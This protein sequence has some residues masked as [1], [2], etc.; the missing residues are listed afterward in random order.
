MTVGTA[1]TGTPQAPSG[2]GFGWVPGALV[3]IAI[4]AVA[5]A[6]LYFAFS[7]DG[8]ATGTVAGTATPVAA[9]VMHDPDLIMAK[10]AN[11]GY[12]PRA[13]V[14]WETVELKRLVNKGLVPAAALEPARVEPLF[15]ENELLEIDL[16]N[17][18]LIPRQAVDWETVETKRLVNM[19]LIP[20]Q[21][22]EG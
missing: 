16:A 5:A 17:R 15:T 20:R 1:Q 12:I 2:V 4:A 14:D 3:A 6:A 11:E 18:G 13:A 8:G 7:D 10:L 22:L 9:A 19:G 21:A